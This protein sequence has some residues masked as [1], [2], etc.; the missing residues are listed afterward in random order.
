MTKSKKLSPVSKRNGV[1][2]ENDHVNIYLCAT[3][4]Y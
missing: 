1:K 4:K 3:C 2:K